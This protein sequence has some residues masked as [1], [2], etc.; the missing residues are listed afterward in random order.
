M[1]L[2]QLPL[3]LYVDLIA[4][5]R[6]LRDGFIW[7]ML[8]LRALNRAQVAQR[9]TIFPDDLAVI[10]V[11][12]ARAEASL[13]W[14]IAR[15]AHRRTGKGPAPVWTMQAAPKTQHA[16]FRRFN[17][18]SDRLDAMDRAVRRLIA[19][20]ARSVAAALPMIAPRRL[21]II[22]AAASR[23]LSASAAANARAPPNPA[24]DRQDPRLAGSPARSRAFARA[25]CERQIS[26]L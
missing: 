1:P 4:W 8:L 10:A 5:G 20:A 26:W 16:L 23:V 13:A 3:W 15:E 6:L 9:K 19:R 17:A 12:F 14:A 25:G 21:P 18:Y 22:R 2:R 11:A 7:L 24:T